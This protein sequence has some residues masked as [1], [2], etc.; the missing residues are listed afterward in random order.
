MTDE[1]IE[2]GFIFGFIDLLERTEAGLRVRIKTLTGPPKHYNR[3]LQR[4]FERQVIRAFMTTLAV[5]LDPGGQLVI[6]DEDSFG[7]GLRLRLRAPAAKKL[8]FHADSAVPLAVQADKSFLAIFP[9]GLRITLAPDG[10]L[11]SAQMSDG[12]QPSLSDQDVELLGPV[13]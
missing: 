3:I 1:G 11:M 4:G 8:G 2:E 12:W 5:R 6:S 13:Q 7:F 9:G 10:L